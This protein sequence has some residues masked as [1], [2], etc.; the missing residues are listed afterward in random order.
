M[1]CIENRYKGICVTCIH[2]NSFS[3]NIVK[4][5]ARKLYFPLLCFR[6]KE[7]RFIYGIAH[8]RYFMNDCQCHKEETR[9]SNICRVYYWILS[10]G[11]LDET[12]QI[13]HNNCSVLWILYFPFIKCPWYV[14]AME[15]FCNNY[16]CS[17][18]RARDNIL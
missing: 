12:K 14:Q 8:N 1:L 9:Y 11:R 16:L 17:E 6:K 15:S 18:V 7:K 5:I 3:S 4:F 13:I 10:I 2:E